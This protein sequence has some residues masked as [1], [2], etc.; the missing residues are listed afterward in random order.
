MFPIT[1]QGKKI[2]LYGHIGNPSV[3]R[4]RKSAASL[5]VNKRLIKHKGISSLISD[6][7]KDYLMKHRHPFYVLL[8]EIPPSHVDCNIHPSKK[9]VKFL[10]EDKF[11][12]ELELIIQDLIKKHFRD[13]FLTKTQK[14]NKQGAKIIQNNQKPKKKYGDTPIELWAPQKKVSNDKNED[15]GL[16]RG[17]QTIEE[18]IQNTQ[19][20][21]KK[22]NHFKNSNANVSITKNYQKELPT[23][24]RKKRKPIQTHFKVRKGKT[25]NKGSNLKGDNNYSNKPQTEQEQKNNNVFE[26]DVI[27]VNRLPF[28]KKLDGGIQGGQLYLVFQ[29]KEELV[30][31]DQHAAHERINYEKVQ[32]LFKKNQIPIQELISPI[33]LE[34]PKNEVEFVKETIPKMRKFGFK[35][36]FFGGNVFLVR[37]IPTIL[38]EKYRS[39]QFIIDTCL[40]IIERGKGKTFKEIKKEIMQYIACHM[41]IVAGDEIR[42]ENKI[43]KLI[44]DLD[45]CENPSYC[46]HGRPT[47]IQLSYKDLDKRFHRT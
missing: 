12:E 14:R 30:I 18:G 15:K 32:K 34:V 3:A 44:K 11:L 29:N 43:R 42:N 6:A 26:H 20:N 2:K 46:A 22:T 33:K 19:N 36:E 1:Y 39:Q 45:A 35:I 7:Y 24:K 25:I 4:S 10:N 38:K 41:S 13:Q 27:P 16:K 21:G 37:S 31:I 17:K 28:L 40:E 9:V 5:F 8:I 47:Y 23:I